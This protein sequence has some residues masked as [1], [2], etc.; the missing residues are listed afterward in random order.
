M[1]KDMKRDGKLYVTKNMKVIKMICVIGIDPG[2]TG[3]IAVLKIDPNTSILLDYLLYNIPIKK[4]SK[5][6]LIYSIPEMAQILRKYSSGY[7]SEETQIFLEDVHSIPRFK[8]RPEVSLDRIIGIWQGI[9]E[10]LE[11]PYTL[12]IPQK[13]KKEFNL[14]THNKKEAI[15]V[16]RELFPGAV[17]QLGRKKDIDKADALL[18][19]EYGRRILK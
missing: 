15:R 13:W 3:A 5:N 7:S 2:L 4:N 18:I 1:I 12:V 6:K 9:I 16:A 17:N 10:T 14:I 11:I 19:A 8:S